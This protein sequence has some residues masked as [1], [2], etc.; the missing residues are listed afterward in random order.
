MMTPERWQQVTNLFHQARAMAPSEREAFVRDACREDPSLANQVL[1]MLAADANEDR[2][3]RLTA[4]SPAALA[5]GAAVGPYRIER[6]IGQGGMGEVFRAT[7]T[8]LH[9][10]VALKVLS[11][12]LARNLE[13]RARF[14]REA[15][16]LA[17]L[18]HPNIGAIYGLENVGD[19]CAL[20][21]ELVEGSTLAERLA[22]GPLRTA[23]AMRI[24]RQIASG[25]EAAHE[26]GI[27][28][29][30]LKPA[31]VKIAPNGSVKILD[32]GIAKLVA[33]DDAA[34]TQTA[35]R[36]EP[37]AAIGTPAYMSPEQL[38]G[39][40]VDKRTDIWAF[41]C[42]LYEMLCGRHAF[43]GDTLPD[44]VAGIVERQ[45]D[46]EALPADTPGSIR[47]L[48]RRC[49][50][51]DPADRLHDIADARIELAEALESPHPALQPLP[52]TRRRHSWWV[53]T[54]VVLSGAG[55]AVWFGSTRLRAPTPGPE[56]LEF[57]LRFP[58]EHRPSTGVAVSPDGRYIVVGLYGTQPQ[59]WLTSLDSSESRLLPGAEGGAFP[60]WS[61]D[62]SQIG[63][64]R[65]GKLWR[66][67]RTG[68][69]ATEICDATFTAPASWNDDNVILFSSGRNLMQVPAS[70]GTPAV[71]NIS[72]EP[73][74]TIVS[75]PQF[76]PDNRHFLFVARQSDTTGVW[77]I[78]S[79]DADRTVDVLA[80]PW[81][82]RF[83]RPNYL[84]FVRGASLVA[85]TLDLQT[86]KLVGPERLLVPSV[87][88]G[89][90]SLGPAFSASE[91]VLAFGAPFAGEPGQL[92]WFDGAGARHESIPSAPQSEYLN[93]SFSPD[94]GSVALNR[95]DPQTGN[96][97]IWIWN[98]ARGIASP[99][100]SD[101]A[102]DSD[103]IWSA[104][105][106]DV[107]F[108][109]TRSGRW[110]FY[111]RSVERSGQDE[112]LVVMDGNP[113]L[114]DWSPDRKYLLYSHRY[115]VSPWSIWAVPLSDER[116]PVQLIAKNAAYGPR[117]SPDGKWIA[118]TDTSTGQLEVHVRPFM[119]EGSAIQISTGTGIHPRWIANGRTL[120]FAKIGGG[121]AAVDLEFGSGTIRVGRERILMPLPV[122]TLNDSRS[123]YDITRDGRWLL[124]RQPAG[125]PRPPYTVVVNWTARVK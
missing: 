84:L 23:D 47:T 111:R 30:D 113:V 34:V 22:A 105:G 103:A 87:L 106:Q 13:F 4:V 57:G 66:I 97:D 2:S 54:L 71:V 20:V 45:P 79:L 25:L 26:K 48:L 70:G 49:L 100:T 3:V 16:L 56:P 110:G 55:L 102:T 117:I 59:I 19:D 52:I 35:G 60:F 31:N 122:A 7:D 1:D 120:V 115:G 92:T 51:T 42:L 108:A 33:N 107:V 44:I 88:P 53:T 17:T 62:G 21:L 77:R 93:P 40:V 119:S 95:M 38:R 14:E 68:G 8:R 5:E 32:F 67:A 118:Y 73:Q 28:H 69:S 36:T 10:P 99:L 41:G 112:E 125:P 58:P 65:G 89:A 75:S 116:K 9:R 101:S 83:A 72:V 11:P 121:L 12:G 46:F 43:A 6:R 63:F 37:G 85:Q 114:G 15:R 29:R 27:V 80:S 104:D 61:R 124:V 82:A 109:S 98:R 24:A 94:G 74:I 78:G 96:W 86:F 91:T 90:L 76:L 123:P 18:N 39:N 81:L 64:F 50:Q